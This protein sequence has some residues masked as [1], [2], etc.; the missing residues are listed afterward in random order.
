MKNE[1]QIDADARAERSVTGFVAPLG[2]HRR[3]ER[4]AV[5]AP[6]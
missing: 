1:T 2:K 5:V 3:P 6:R 4:D